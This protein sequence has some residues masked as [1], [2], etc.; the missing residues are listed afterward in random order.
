MPMNLTDI[1]YEFWFLIP[2]FAERPT[3][4]INDVEEV[5]TKFPKIWEATQKF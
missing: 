1:S 5:R 2:L 4:N 3:V